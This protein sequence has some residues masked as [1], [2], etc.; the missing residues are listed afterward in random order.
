MK[1]VYLLVFLA[2]FFDAY[3]QPSAFEPDISRALFHTRLDQAQREALA[4]DGKADDQ[5]QAY[6]DDEVNMLINFSLVQRIDQWQRKV[7][8]DSTLSSAEKITRLR[9]MTELI[10]QFG[11]EARK[12]Q[13][14]WNQFPAVLQSFEQGLQLMQEKK[15]LLP[16]FEPLPYQASQL[17]SNNFAFASYNRVQELKEYLLLKYLAEN[18]KQIMPKLAIHYDYSYA[19][20]LISDVARQRPEELIT[21]VQARNTGIARKILASTDP[22]VKQITDLAFDNRGQLYLPFLDELSQR[23]TTKEEIQK[24]VADSTQYYSLLVKT[25]LSYASRMAKG[26]T[27]VSRRALQDMLRRKSMETYV[28]TIN[29]LHD[30]P[31]AIRFKSIAKLTVPELYYLIVMNETEIYTSSYMYV[32]NQLFERMTSKSAD[33][34]LAL[35]SHDRYKKFLTMASNYNTLDNFLSRMSPANATALMTAFVNNLDRGSGTDDIEDAVDVANAYASIKDKKIKTLMLQE[36]S[37][38][39]E[40]AMAANNHKAMVIYRLE[41]V[42]MES[43]LAEGD[44]NAMQVNMSQSLGLPPVYEIKNDQLR[45]DK[46]RIVLQMYFYGDAAGKGTFNHLLRLYGDRSKWTMKATND[47]V[48]FT[49]VGTPVPFVLFANRALDEEKDEDEQ[50]QRNLIAW[51]SENGFHPSISVHRG[52]SYYL[53]YTIEKLLPSKVVV[54]GSCGA[55]HNLNDILRKSPDAYIISSKQVGYGEINVALFTYLVDRLKMGLDVRWPTMLQEV[56]TRISAGKKEGF[57]DYIFPHQNLGALF[58]K[59][60]RI[61][62]AQNPGS[63]ADS[64]P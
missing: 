41:K 60:Y 21:Y 13:L 45:D 63:M 11:G 12:K 7:E 27:P 57:D 18:P 62:N 58:I 10:N 33:S 59:A 64:R 9:G 26:D 40:Q 52:H 51:M 35:V 61:A 17:L 46:G 19:D 34:L 5:L 43:N 53:K 15:S 22:L 54:L 28:N 23:K 20:S 49:S 14:G 47:W 25:Q 24:A 2:V 6:T 8:F 16:V 56:S 1:Q 37:K 36:V 29:G 31:A 44:S 39:L 55:Y 4:W 48:Q 30:E 32:Y 42:I 38:S 50:A 3:A